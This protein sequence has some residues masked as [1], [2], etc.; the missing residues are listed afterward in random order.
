MWKWNEGKNVEIKKLQ[1][2]E[3]EAEAHAA[4]TMKDEH[5]KETVRDECKKIVKM[6]TFNCNQALK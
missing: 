1:T 3:A 6:L 2:T 4:I 5:G